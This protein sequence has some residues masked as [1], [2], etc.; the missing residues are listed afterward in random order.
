MDVIG[1]K[2]ISKRLG[3]SQETAR[4]YLKRRLFES[5]IEHRGQAGRIQ[6]KTTMRGLLVFMLKHGYPLLQ[7]EKEYL[8]KVTLK[9]SAP[10]G[11]GSQK[12]SARM[13]S[14]HSS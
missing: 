1:S 8:E 9:L 10:N 11:D 14:L 12:E 5:T 13:E 6:I 7:E 2:V 3:V 4:G